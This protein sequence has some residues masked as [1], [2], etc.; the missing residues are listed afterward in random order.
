MIS[1]ASSVKCLGLIAAFFTPIWLLIFILGSP[2]LPRHGPR[3][4]LGWLLPSATTVL[5]DLLGQH[6]GV[7]RFPAA[8]LSRIEYGYLKV[9]IVLVY[10]VSTFAVTGTGAVLLAA[11][12]ELVAARDAA[13]PEPS[14]IDVM[15]MRRV[16][17]GAAGEARSTR[18]T[19]AA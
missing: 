15:M 8:F 11:A 5:I 3:F 14:L 13:A 17:G 1:V 2:L 12:E 7:W 9:D 18:T 16:S 19:K 10:T 4:L 6:Q